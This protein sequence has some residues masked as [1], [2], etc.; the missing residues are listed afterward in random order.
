[1]SVEFKGL[2]ELVKELDSLEKKVKN[3][4]AKVAVEE[5]SEV[6][7]NALKDEAPK[8]DSNSKNSYSYL[9][10]DIIQ[11]NDKVHSQMGINSKNWEYTKGLWYQYWGFSTHKKGQK[12]KKVNKT[13]YGR[14]NIKKSENKGPS[15]HPP[16]YWLDRAFDKSITRCETI[17]EQKIREGL[18]K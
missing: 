18:G 3:K 4:I 12:G 10:K 9:E 11:S 5:A 6:M 14:K 13:S 7:L 15:F 8:A 17:M 1:M 16:D 2:D